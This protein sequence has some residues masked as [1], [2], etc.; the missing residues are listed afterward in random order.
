MSI[1]KK[2]FSVDD[3]I[4]DYS[5]IDKKLRILNAGSASVRF[6]D[7]CVNIDIQEKPNIDVV[8]DVHNLPDTLGTFD[9]II[10]NAVLQYCNDPKIVA[11]QF[12]QH[13]IPGGYLFVDAP[14]VQPYCQD[15][16]DK[17]RFSEDGLKEVFS[18]FEMIEVGPSIIPGSAFATLGV[19]I[20]GDL[21]ANKYI[22]FILAKI[23]YVLLY[24][25]SRIRT[26]KEKNT[27]GA[28]YLIARRPL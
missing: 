16:P 10:C 27:A 3:F 11:D 23:A 14:W 20:A 26:K 22:S 18:Q 24:P 25:F 15:M 17:F 9:I 12:Y 21:A 4:R 13:L 1:F 28:F 7:N 5:V 2:N 19:K 8:C 6:G